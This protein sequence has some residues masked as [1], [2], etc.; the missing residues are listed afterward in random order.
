MSVLYQL[1]LQF[2]YVSVCMSDNEE[3]SNLVIT[4][5]LMQFFAK[6]LVTL[7][8]WKLW[9]WIK[10][11]G[12]RYLRSL[13]AFCCLFFAYLIKVFFFFF[14]YYFIFLYLFQRR[15]INNKTSSIQEIHIWFRFLLIVVPVYESNFSRICYTRGLI[16]LIGQILVSFGCFASL[17]F[18]R[19]QWLFPYKL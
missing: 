2:L 12:L 7:T 6:W 14:Y 9:P 19:S 1:W 10:G 16:V 5:I 17:R 18:K 15:H 4:S 13:N 11:R 8:H 3:K